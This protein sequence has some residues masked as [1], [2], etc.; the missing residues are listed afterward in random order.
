[1]R[2]FASLV[3]FACLFGG[4]TVEARGMT[5][6]DLA[7]LTP[8]EYHDIF[9]NK[10]VTPTIKDFRGHKL[11]GLIL[12]IANWGIGK[13]VYFLYT[14]KMLDALTGKLYSQ[15]LTFQ[16]RFYP[17]DN[18]R[19]ESGIN[20]WPVKGGESMPMKIYLSPA[21]ED[22]SIESLKIDYAVPSNNPI[23]EQILV[24]EVRQIPG[25]HLYLGK[26]YYR[27]FG[28]YLF[29]LWFALEKAD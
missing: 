29:F 10:C 25:S 21:I 2:K 13:R 8:E 1:M 19:G 4:L 5:L 3:F 26:M 28:R 12:D 11:N 17:A 20:F 23:T 16:K 22:S 14:G 27:E 15:Q 7:S 18:E 24:D 9:V 6:W